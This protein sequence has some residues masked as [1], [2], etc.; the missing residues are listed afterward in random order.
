MKRNLLCFVAISVVF[1]LNCFVTPV[2]AFTTPDDN[3]E[4]N[5]GA[6]KSQ[7]TTGGSYDAHSGN[8][9]RVVTD[10]HLPGALS[11]LG[12]DF[13]RYWNSVPNDAEN[14]YAVLPRSFA[15]SNWSHSWEWYANEEDTS[16]NY[17]GD[18]TEEIFTT[19]ITV[20]FPD[21]H[22]TRYK[23]TR[24][25]HN[26][27]DFVHNVWIWAD[28]RCG[29]PYTAAEQNGFQ[30]GGSIYD[31]LS[32]MAANGSNFWIYRADGSSVHFTGGPGVYQ[33]TG[34]FDSHGLRTA[35][36][37]YADGTLYRVTE[38]G[39]R[40]LQL[41]W[42]GGVIASVQSG[43][44]AGSQT[45]NYIYTSA[46]DG[47]M[48]G[49][50]SGGVDGGMSISGP[51]GGM[52]CSGPNWTVLRGVSYP[53]GTAATYTYAFTFGDD[54]SVHETGYPVLKYADDP[55]FA[56]AMTR[57]W[58][59]Y[60]ASSCPERAPG[61][62]NRDY[63][64]AN[65]L[66]LA[67]E[68]SGET[69][70]TVSSFSID[71]YGGTR[72]ETNG[73]N[74]WREF[75]FGDSAG[76]QGTGEHLGYQLIKL[77]DYTNQY[78]FPSNLPFTRQ[79]W[80]QGQPHQIWDGR[81][82]ETDA[83]VAGFNA[84]TGQYGD[85]SGLPTEI[86]NVTA[87]GSYQVFDRINP[88]AS[89]PQDYSRIPNRFNHWLFTYRDERGITRTYT[90]D[91]RRRVRR[92]DYAEGS[93]EIFGYDPYGY[94]KVAYHRLASGA[95]EY[96]GIDGY[97]R[98]VW[99]YNSID[100][101]DARTDFIYDDPN[102]RDLPHKVIDARARSS[103][104]PY[105]TRTE[106]DS[107][108]RVV[109]MHYPPTGGS[110]DPT[111]WYGYDAHGN[112]NWIS[113]ELAQYPQ[114]PAHT[115]RYGYDTYRRCIWYEEPLNAPD[116]NGT[117][118]ASRR[119]DWLYD[120]WIDGVGWRDQSVHT[121]N[122]W[123]IQ[124]GPA[125]DS[126]GDRPMI[127]RAHDVNN[128]LVIEQT[129][130]IQPAA[131]N[132]YP[133]QDLETHYFSYDENGQ[134]KTYTD[135]MGRL[136]TYDYDLRNRLW[137][138]NET[139]NSVP[140]TTEILY[141]PTGNK[142]DVNFPAESGGQRSQHWRDYDAFGQSQTFIDERNNVTN[143]TYCWG[144]M[145]KLYTVT[146]HRDGD[147]G[148]T[149]D[150][151]TWF[152]YDAMG[153][154]T[155]VQ[156]PD[157]SHET[158]TYECSSTVG[159]LCDQPHT[160]TTRKGHGQPQTKTFTYDARGRETRHE[161]SDGQTSPIYRDWD[162]GGRLTHISN[163][164]ANIYF[165]YDDAAQLAWESDYIAG[166]ATT[167]TTSYRRYATGSVWA[168]CYP[169]GLWVTRDYT[170]R[171][172]LNTESENSTGAWRTLIDYNYNADGKVDYQDYGNGVRSNYDYDPRGYTS[173]V[174]HYRISP[175]QNYSARTYW[176]DERDR[177]TA[178]QKSGDN[179]V[180]PMENS[181]GNR[182]VYDPE[183]QLTDAYYGAWD[184]AGN[185]SSWERED[186]FNLDPLGNRRGWDYMPTKGWQN[187]T[188]KD[189]GLNQYRM[190]SPYS[191]INYDDDIGGTWGSPGHANGVIMQDG[192]VTAGYNAL[193]QPM[194]IWSSPVGWTYFGYDGLGRCV[195]RWNDTGAV[196]YMYYEGPNL[197]Q[198]GPQS[199]VADR[200]YVN[201]ARIDEVVAQITPSNN[202]IRYF[203]YDANGNCTLQ[204]DGGG[205][206]V[207][208]YDYDAFG[209][210]Y[211]YDAW[212]NNIGY[213]PWGN[214]MLFTGREWLREL[215][216]Y[217]YRNRLYNPELGRFM[218][219]DP[220]E[221]AAGD[222]NLYR[223]C[224]NDPVNRVD[225]TG[226]Q[227]AKPVTVALEHLRRGVLGSNI[228]QYLT[229]VT[230]KGAFTDLA[231]KV[232]GDHV[233]RSQAFYKDGTKS[234][235]GTAFY[236]TTARLAQFVKDHKHEYVPK[237]E[238]HGGVGL[239]LHF[240]GDVRPGDSTTTPSVPGE[241]SDAVKGTQAPMLYSAES[242]YKAQRGF[243]LTP[244]GQR[245]A[246]QTP[247][248]FNW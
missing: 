23:I 224:H 83:V 88:G 165:G 38:D 72:M 171:G 241:D 105:S 140:R 191:I 62:F 96:F 31:Y 100:G 223:Y 157:G 80:L 172:Q 163:W 35:L 53:E 152:S 225:P 229:I 45:V 79:N 36:D 150:Q 244:N 209:F 227:D 222:Y 87:D 213:S 21:G 24:S 93:Y 57:I 144:P 151:R 34:I 15:A 179:S 181:R 49:G 17:S 40:F 167:V 84:N 55:R 155:D 154:P 138:T 41:N 32:D 1:C 200:T 56:G 43:G 131:G 60:R 169:N 170:A 234:K 141:D 75:Y 77:T 239:L 92:I 51:D 106:Y 26:H 47:D 190:W 59:T 122:E 212:G 219:P 237:G 22:A 90:R 110:S 70:Q 4:G 192:W 168:T 74:G 50:G 16:D 205:N 118:V 123:R 42:S 207:E 5:T 145:K 158:T 86:H 248:Y 230:I 119:W 91:S 215:K 220:K 210:P 176:R 111:V 130:W 129:G 143:L 46:C 65:A 194:Y 243:L 164:T 217:D 182:Y 139:V 166:A 25:N 236:V 204:T 156:F 29:A 81:G 2:V 232:M 33:A 133:S 61:N 125:F 175:Y 120:R 226:L 109:E 63:F 198:E 37:Y 216:L 195:K 189:N 8:A 39:G 187:F 68:E 19:A 221:F 235:V 153:K 199:S 13:I 127:A 108:N 180:N 159:Y 193:N 18:G 94:N 188:R 117:P 20:T 98:L 112:C 64:A 121:K 6:L 85:S 124:F 137:K 97:G 82:I 101:W 148:G 142:T 242:L 128:R 162:D 30:A 173:W 160:F 54:T 11:T 104:A 177:I 231:T 208:Q 89:D 3:P 114:N 99:Q 147:W 67:K 203:H 66:S 201:G 48:T 52:T 27:Y 161:W 78:P 206:I 238:G 184:P 12:L 10:L 102:H 149:E 113:D 211:F 214:R 197:I 186:H 116:G 135:P 240:H 14:S 247:V 71:C 28:P 95:E 76:Y 183:G 246:T 136:T 115:K 174:H 44:P 134:K 103:G 196:R 233:D 218:Q 228:P 73:I 178:W 9:T 7:V 107:A 132:W 126:S 202:W 58:Y 146:T 245:E 185:P 69:R